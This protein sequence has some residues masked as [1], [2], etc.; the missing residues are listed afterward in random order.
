MNILWQK[1]KKPDGQ[2]LLEA[3]VALAM[4]LYFLSGTAILAFRH[5]NT[6]NKTNDLSAVG[7]IG[8]ESLEAIQSIVYND[9]PVLVAGSYG[10]T[11]TSGSW[12]LQISPDTV[13]SKYLRTVNIS[14]VRRDIDCNI[15]SSGGT[16]DPDMKLVTINIGWQDFNIPRTRSFAQYFTRWDAPTTCVV[17]GQAGYL[18][19]DVSRASIDST[20][21]VMVGV[22]FINLSEVPITIDKLTLNWTMPGDIEW[23]KIE[24]T[25]YWHATNGTGTPQ[26]TQPSGTELNIVDAVIPAGETYDADGFRFKQKIDGSTVTIKATMTDGTSTLEVTT[27][28]FEP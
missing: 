15:V 23:I 25:N 22:K 2:N 28:P 20:K 10:L 4:F 8:E 21:K 12:Q 16:I 19:I 18:L 11:S 6:I 26:G 17:K 5:L 7:L 9:W 14:P 3:L 27:L 24:G 1:I 13:S